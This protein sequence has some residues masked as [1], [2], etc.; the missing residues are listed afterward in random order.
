MGL[1]D[2]T[3][4]HAKLVQRGRLLHH[5]SAGK[6]GDLGSFRAYRGTP[7]VHMF[8][9]MRQQSHASLSVLCVSIEAT[10]FGG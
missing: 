7:A 4:C 8:W 10:E 6:R 9:Q 3:L 2:A 5:V 1:F